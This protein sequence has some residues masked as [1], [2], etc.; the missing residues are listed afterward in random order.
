[1]YIPPYTISDE[2]MNMLAAICSQLSFAP[3]QPAPPILTPESLQQMH[4][5]LGGDG[6]FRSHGN[7]PHWVPPLID[8]LL[9]WF[10]QSEAHLL[11]RSAVLHYELMSIYPFS[12]G[13]EA[14]ATRVQQTILAQFHPK[15]A[16]ISLIFPRQEYEWA[17]S[18]LDASSFISLS[19]RTLL[20]VLSQHLPEPT[21]PQNLAPHA[22]ELA[23]YVRKHPGS[24]RQDILQALPHLSARMLDR[25]LQAL[26]E[27]R[28]IEYRGS[29]K[30]GA[31]FPCSCIHKES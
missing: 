20:Q 5:E 12:G 25:H 17:I 4:R 8:S 23:N 31:Y 26:R 28:R 16:G 1:M 13:N 14:L 3:L 15:F 19:L 22:E 2:S 11:I 10:R 24:K 7:R 29:R 30:T 27:N 6:V 18:A 21:S 9:S